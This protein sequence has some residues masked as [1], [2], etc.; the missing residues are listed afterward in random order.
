MLLTARQ[1]MDEFGLPSLSTV[2]TMRRR[3]LPFIK[4]SRNHLFDRNDVIR[5]IEGIKEKICREEITGPTSNTIRPEI[6]TTSS[7][8]NTGLPAS[9]PRV[10]QTAEKL[11]SLS[12]GSSRTANGKD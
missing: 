7:I 9:A 4:I 6:A 10:H 2:A 11:K 12:R 3:G 1:V 5:F 8:A